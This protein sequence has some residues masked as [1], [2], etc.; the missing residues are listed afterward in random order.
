MS[1]LEMYGFTK[2]RWLQ[3][4]LLNDTSQISGYALVIQAILYIQSMGK[5]IHCLMGFE[6]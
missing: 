1:I 5:T 6:S 3:P 2:V 4:K